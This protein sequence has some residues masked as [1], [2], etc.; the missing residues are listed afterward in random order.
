MWKRTIEDLHDA[1]Y[2][3]STFVKAAAVLPFIQSINQSINQSI[4]HSFIHS[5]IQLAIHSVD[6]SGRWHSERASERVSERELRLRFQ[7][8]KGI[9][10]NA[11]LLSLA[12]LQPV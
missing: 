9:R 11:L 1:L 3:P 5:F 12:R 6:H 10:A 4:I 7:G 2:L 8:N